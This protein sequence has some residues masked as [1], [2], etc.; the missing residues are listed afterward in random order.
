MR[1][2]DATLYFNA[3]RLLLWTALLLLLL[4]N[5]SDQSSAAVAIADAARLP[6]T[7]S[8]RSAALVR[9]RPRYLSSRLTGHVSSPLA[10]GLQSALHHQP[11]VTS[12]LVPKAR[13]FQGALPLPIH[14]WHNEF[15]RKITT[16]ILPSK[17]DGKERK[18]QR[19]M[20]AR[21]DAD[22]KL[23]DVK[24]WGQRTRTAARPTTSVDIMRT[25]LID[26]IKSTMASLGGRISSK[27][28][29]T[30]ISSANLARSLSFWESMVCGAVSRSVSQKLTHPANSMKTILQSDQT[31]SIRSLMQRKNLQRLTQG[32]GAQLVLSLPQGAVNFA[33]LEATRKVLG[34][35]AKKAKLLQSDDGRNPANDVV[36]A[37]L[38]FVSSAAST[39]CCIVVTGPITVISDN[40]MSGNYKNLPG[41]ISGIASQNGIEG[42]Y[43][44]W[45][46]Q[47]A[48]KV[49]S[50]AVTWVFFQRLKAIHNAIFD[51]PLS[52][53]DNLA[54]GSLASGAT[55][56]IM[57]P[58]D[59]IK[60]RLVTQAGQKGAATAVAPYLGLHDTAVRMIREEGPAS[61]YRGLTPRLASVVPMVAI[62]F[63]VYEAM[64]KRMLE[65][66]T[67]PTGSK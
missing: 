54:I 51:R 52:N 6:F 61:L 30:A 38:D 17:E 10:V 32:A 8:A 41:A 62:Q 7:V 66:E 12:I 29:S 58:L 55:V 1:Q 4:N 22:E 59:T 42:F 5:S 56:C 21:L 44:G 15:V 64:K 37:C 3:R 49:P 33:V 13:A 18:Q 53:T 65:R 16:N 14:Y 46:T 36:G 31:A 47:L 57:M 2:S 40:I 26:G 19:E 23:S 20:P 24:P 34:D 35:L 60:T 9:S 11:A 45:E 67:A 50:Y 48:A 39:V 25:R 43:T 27:S 63:A 28:S